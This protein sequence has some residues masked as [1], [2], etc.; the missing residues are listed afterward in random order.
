MKNGGIVLVCKDQ[1]NNFINDVKEIDDSVA[2]TKEEKKQIKEYNKS[3]VKQRKTELPPVYEPLY[4]NCEL[5]FAISEKLGIS[6]TEKNKIEKILHSDGKLFLSEQIESRFSFNK[7]SVSSK[8][9]FSTKELIV[10]MNCLSEKSVISVVVTD[11]GKSK[12]YDD[13]VV[14]KIDRSADKI[15]SY[16]VTYKSKTFEKQEW[17][18]KSTVKVTILDD[19]KT[20]S[21]G[22]TK[23]FKVKN[24]KHYPIIPD[25]VSFELV[26]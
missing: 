23:N 4:I 13:W 16:T 25:S 19:E 15:S 21:N 2:K 7:K 14:D 10:P 9:D 20:N 3:I 17:S 22:I 11:S 1:N 18:A 24:Y 8:I 12:K 26:K 5:L 6:D